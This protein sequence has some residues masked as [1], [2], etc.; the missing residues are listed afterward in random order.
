MEYKGLNKVNYYNLYSKFL[1]KEVKGG[2]EG[3]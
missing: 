1:L 3:E 2:E